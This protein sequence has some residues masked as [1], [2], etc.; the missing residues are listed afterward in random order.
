MTTLRNALAEFP[1]EEDCGG[2]SDVNERGPRR[3]KKGASRE[4][5][6]GNVPLGLSWCCP[7]GVAV[8]ARAQEVAGA[9]IWNVG[10]VA[11]GVF[12]ALPPS[13]LLLQEAR[14]VA[15]PWWGSPPIKSA[16]VRR[17]LLQ[18]KSDSQKEKND[19]FGNSHDRGINLRERDRLLILPLL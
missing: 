4:G 13:A 1:G 7:P 19:I 17:S 16:K 3:E 14:G 12:P 9:V 15:A 2:F 10:R 8:A 5:G 18:L 6:R 11:V